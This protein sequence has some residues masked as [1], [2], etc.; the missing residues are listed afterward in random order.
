[1]LFQDF[2]LFLQEQHFSLKFS[3]ITFKFLNS[4]IQNL[5]FLQI[6]LIGYLWRTGGNTTLWH[7][8]NKY[9]CTNS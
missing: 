4:V 1:M 3:Y 6:F 2:T 9:K 5:Y 7:K 8:Y